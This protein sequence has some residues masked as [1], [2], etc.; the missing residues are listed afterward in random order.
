MPAG[1]LKFTLSWLRYGEQW[2]G[3]GILLSSHDGSTGGLDV[4]RIIETAK[5]E[6]SSALNEGWPASTVTSVAALERRIVDVTI[7]VVFAFSN[8]M[9]ECGAKWMECVCA[10]RYLRTARD[11]IRNRSA[12]ASRA[13]R[14]MRRN[15]EHEDRWLIC[16]R[17]TYARAGCYPFVGTREREREMDHRHRD[18]SRDKFPI[19]RR[20]VNTMFLYFDGE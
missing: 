13:C 2:R 16:T 17:F 15:R 6:I 20:T 9:N 11:M 14:S 7:G 19:H 5:N 1:K 4:G 8:P 10:R 3:A 12:P 18:N